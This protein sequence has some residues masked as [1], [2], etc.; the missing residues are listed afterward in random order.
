MTGSTYYPF[1]FHLF[2]V[3]IMDSFPQNNIL[4]LI[5][6]FSYLFLEVHIFLNYFVF[7]HIHHIFHINFYMIVL[8]ILNSFYS[9][10]FYKLLQMFL[11]ILHQ[12]Y[13]I[14]P[15]PFYPPLHPFTPRILPI[16]G[17]FQIQFIL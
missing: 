8:H 9:N 14:V 12:N 15:Y 4:D 17:I 3:H 10:S 5:C 7:V 13:I 16:I 6:I 11:L 2:F 1:T